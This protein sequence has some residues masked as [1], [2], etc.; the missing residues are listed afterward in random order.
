MERAIEFGY[1]LSSEE[2][3][4]AKLVEY[5]VR[6]EEVGFS[7]ALISDHYHPW[8]DSQGQSAFVWSVLGGIAGA[9]E[10]LR[11]G[12]GVTCPTIRIHP[13]VIAQA[14]ATVAD[15]MPGRFF[16]G[17]GS[18]ENLNEHVVGLGWPPSDVRLDMLSEAIDVIREL[19]KGE[20]TDFRGEHFQVEEARI[21]TLP[22]QLPPIYV[23]SG[24]SSSAR[25]AGE[26][27][28]GLIST[29]LDS[30]LLERFDAA[31]GRGKP[32]YGQL[33]V[34]WAADEAEARRIAH[35]IWPTSALGASLKADLPSPRHFQ[36]AIEPITEEM[37]AQ[38]VVCGPDPER[39]ASAIQKY[40]DTGYDYVYIHH[41]GPDQEGFFHFYERDILPRFAAGRRTESVTSR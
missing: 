15:M 18:G 41:I 27:G 5:A 32:R 26:K 8:L 11:V 38:D 12:T 36:E 25:L 30:E 14:A 24:G 39:H 40:I 4:P 3:R 1:A 13:A 7:F 29:S 20:A 21:Y 34:C 9:T 33:A 6:A 35:N 10:K 28:D 37:V 2:H 22:E 23:A 17:V 31:G 16:L 19:W